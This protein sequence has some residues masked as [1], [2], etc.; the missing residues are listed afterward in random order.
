MTDTPALPGAAP[1]PSAASALDALLR[2]VEGHDRDATDGPWSW[3]GGPRTGPPCVL[4]SP[5]F[6]TPEVV[7]MDRILP[8]LI[9]TNSVLRDD[10]GCIRQCDAEAIASYR[11]AAPR[12][13]AIVRVLVEAVTQ[14]ASFGEGPVVG[15]EFDCPYHAMEARHA[16]ARAEAIAKG[17]A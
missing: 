9:P 11:T 13:A 8:S 15:P 2:E 1:D 6:H 14:A 12:L 5:A 16:L 10:V 3:V 7:E 4:D 17:D